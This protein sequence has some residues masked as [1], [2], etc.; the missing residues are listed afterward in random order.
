MESA[1]LCRIVGILQHLLSCYK[2]CETVV[3]LQYSLIIFPTFSTLFCCLIMSVGNVKQ[4]THLKF[5]KGIYRLAWKWIIRPSTRFCQTVS[6][7]VDLIQ[8]VSLSICSVHTTHKKIFRF[9]WN[10]VCRKSDARRC[11]IW[12]DTKSRSGSQDLEISKIITLS[13]SISSAI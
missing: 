6:F 1:N 11:S 13:N 10:L 5:R 7:W 2:L 8:Q 12:H 9:P 3:F 4:T